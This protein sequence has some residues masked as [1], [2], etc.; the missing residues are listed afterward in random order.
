MATATGRTGA[1]RGAARRDAQVVAEQLDVFDGDTS[2]LIASRGDRLRR[3]KVKRLPLGVLLQP[4]D[5]GGDDK[6]I[7]GFTCVGMYRRTRQCAH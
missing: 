7:H 2:A 6:R 3:R 5:E 1:G 4:A